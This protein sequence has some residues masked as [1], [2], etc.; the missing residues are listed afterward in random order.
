MKAR[1]IDVLDFGPEIIERVGPEG[2]EALFGDIGGHFNESGYRL[3]AEI[4]R[5]HL[6]ERGVLE[7]P[8]QD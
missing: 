1:N 3:L 2:I 7:E 6:L 5:D 4:T 8:P